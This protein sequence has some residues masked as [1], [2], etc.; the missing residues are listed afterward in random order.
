[1]EKEREVLTLE[2][3]ADEPEVGRWLS[4]ME[5]SRRDTL[6]GV[7]GLTDEAMDWRP[8]GEPNTVGTLLYHTALVEADWLVVDMFGR[9]GPAWPAEL[10]PFTD[11]DLEGRLT[12]VD[13]TPLGEH[14]ERMAAVRAML[15]EAM[16]SMTSEEF[17]R[18]RARERFDISAAWI[19][20]HLLQHEAEHRSQIARLR[21]Q[22]PSSLG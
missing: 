19:I 5:D 15:L 7:A 13:G 16:R 21:E 4:A 11:R 20:H 2:P 3:I 18:V 14:L 17:H 22:M 8:E 6:E 10:L 1:M 12:P 9:E